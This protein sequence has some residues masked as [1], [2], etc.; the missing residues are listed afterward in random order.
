MKVDILAIG[1]HPD[2]IELSCSGYLLKEIGRGK[3]VALLDLTEGELGT[4][5]DR[6]LR[7]KEAMAAAKKMGAISREILNIGDG[8]FEIEKKNILQIIQHIRKYQPTI[9][10]ANAIEDRHPDHARAAGLVARA[11]FLSGLRKIA[12]KAGKKPQQVWRPKAIYHYTQ[13]NPLKPDVIVDISPFIEQKMELIL[14]YSSQF[15]NPNSKEPDSPISS[16]EFLDAVKAKCTCYGR[17]IQVKYAEGFNVSRPIA[18]D[19][20]LALD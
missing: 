5:G 14:T 8:F 2:D 13:D 7:K 15:Y 12:T 18:T 19:S 4:R 10:L 1:V 3:T 6:I 17:Y 16:R 9:V 11:C 20:L